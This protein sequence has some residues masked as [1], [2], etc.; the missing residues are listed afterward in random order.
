V[1]RAEGDRWVMMQRWEDPAAMGEIRWTPPMPGAY[2][3]EA[4]IVPEHARPYVP[5]LEA[6]VRELPWIYGNPILIT[7]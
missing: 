4:R 2:R 1:Y 6:R 7:P 5:G 3:V